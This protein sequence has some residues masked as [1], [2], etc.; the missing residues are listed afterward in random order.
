M[1]KG[2]KAK[3]SGTTEITIESGDSKKSPKAKKTTKRGPKKAAQAQNDEPN[4]AQGPPV[5]SKGKTN[6]SKKQPAVNSIVNYLKPAVDREPIAKIPVPKSISKPN[7]PKNQVDEP[8]DVRNLI[9][10]LNNK[11]N[12]W[13]KLMSVQVEGLIE[14]WKSDCDD[15]ELFDLRRES[16]ETEPVDEIKQITDKF[17]KIYSDFIREVNENDDSKIVSSLPP[18]LN[19]SAKN[20]HSNVGL[21]SVINDTVEDLCS[22]SNTVK[23]P[24]KTDE[25]KSKPQIC[26]VK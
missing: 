1:R 8:P 12:T 15:F 22:W 11:D 6:T 17:D 2:A 26:M 13:D 21:N 7:Q 5:V 19:T 20:N 18:S 16:D 3:N 24:K 10:I 9:K 25:Q 14:S 4:G 23:G